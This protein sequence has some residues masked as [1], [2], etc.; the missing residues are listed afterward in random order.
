[1]RIDADPGIGEFGHV[2]AADHDEAGAT[3]P[4]YHRRV[5][6][7]GWRIVE[8]ARTGAGH[9]TLDVEQI[10]DRNRNAGIGRRRGSDLA[11]PVHCF[12]RFGRGFR[13]DVNEGPRAFARGVGDPGQALLDQ[14][15]GA[16][17]TAVEFLGQCG[18][19]RR[20][21]HGLIASLLL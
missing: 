5:G 13:I 16:G 6:F 20:V 7:R 11:Q 15:A 9:L 8:R 19:C 21:R 3:Q 14:L 2:G 10:L 17:A 4:S 1:M 18:K 12:R